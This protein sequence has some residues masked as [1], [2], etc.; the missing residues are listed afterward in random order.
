LRKKYYKDKTT[1]LIEDFLVKMKKEDKI[2]KD[3]LYKKK[4]RFKKKKV[5]KLTGKIKEGDYY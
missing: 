5:E 1:Q 4:N 2:K 3:L